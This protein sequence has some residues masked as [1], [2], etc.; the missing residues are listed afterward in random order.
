[1]VGE[2]CSCGWAAAAAQPD[3]HPQDDDEAENEEDGF[4]AHERKIGSTDAF[5]FFP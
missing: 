2:V 1:M 3:R 4:N 5:L